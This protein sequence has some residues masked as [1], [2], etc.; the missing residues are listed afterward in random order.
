MGKL[1]L[2]PGGSPVSGFNCK[3]VAQPGPAHQMPHP[4]PPQPLRKADPPGALLCGPPQGGSSFDSS[5]GQTHWPQSVHRGQAQTPPPYWLS[6]AGGALVIQWWG[7][8][9]SG[10]T[11]TRRLLAG[12]PS[13]SQSQV[14]PAQTRTKE[15]RLPATHSSLHLFT[16]Q[17]FIKYPR[18]TRH[19]VKHLTGD[20]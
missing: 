16:Q 1:R 10:E 13:R 15:T 14:G 20:C 6:R 8:G 11:R 7:L 18:S 4:K 12:R 19:S 5:S 2:C 17:T 9:R 3:L